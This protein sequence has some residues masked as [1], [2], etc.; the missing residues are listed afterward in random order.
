MGL[1]D[2][3]LDTVVIVTRSLNDVLTVFG[4]GVGASHGVSVLAIDNTGLCFLIPIND[5]TNLIFSN[6]SALNELC[7]VWLR[8]IR[9]VMP[10]V[11]CLL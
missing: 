8:W 11:I 5:L 2:L 10:D 7:R 9:G 6:S 4:D 1:V 3:D